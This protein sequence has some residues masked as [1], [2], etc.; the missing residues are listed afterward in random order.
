MKL[1][2]VNV[3][4][5]REV[6]WQKRAVRTSIWKSP[7]EG[8]VPVSKLN[9]DGDEQSDLS[10]HG[11][12]DK[13]EREE[14]RESALTIADVVSLYTSD[15]ENQVLLRRASE[16]AALPESWREYFRKRLWDADS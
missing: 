1:I 11:G 4:L 10:V 6:P 3:G 12:P 9:L 8:R 16:L 7:V 15:A 14:D 5:P 2:S 13:I